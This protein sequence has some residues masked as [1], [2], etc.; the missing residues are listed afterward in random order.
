MKGGGGGGYS[1]YQLTRMMQ[2][3]FWVWTF[4]FRVFWGRKIWQIY[5]GCSKHWRFVVVP[6]YPSRVI[7]RK[8]GKGSFW[9]Q[10]NFW[11]RYFLGFCLK[12]KGIFWVLIFAPVRSSP[13]P[14]IRSTP[15]GQHITNN[16]HLKSLFPSLDLA[17]YWFSLSKSGVLLGG[18]GW[19]H[20]I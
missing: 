10:F 12:P 11:S 5:F 3:V 9:G 8:F 17:S 19:F 6:V 18:C 2:G 15:P 4:R 7:L 13:S 14:E 20:D 1:G 16:P